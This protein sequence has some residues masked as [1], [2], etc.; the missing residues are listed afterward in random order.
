MGGTEI[1]LRTKIYVIPFRP[2]SVDLDSLD[3]DSRLGF[4]DRMPIRHF[5]RR[6]V[7]PEAR[8]EHFRG[9]VSE[10]NVMWEKEKGAWRFGDLEVQ[11]RKKEAILRPK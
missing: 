8:K 5:L 9:P 6:H 10:V 11:V 1:E 2:A 3:S 7:T 4:M